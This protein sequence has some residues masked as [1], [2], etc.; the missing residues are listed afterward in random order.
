MSLNSELKSISGVPRF[1][2]DQEKFP[3][4]QVKFEAL[5]YRLGSKYT[6]AIKGKKEEKRSDK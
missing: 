4:F 1:N 2:G 6:K 3:I 5:I